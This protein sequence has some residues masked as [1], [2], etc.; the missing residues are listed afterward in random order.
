[1][2]QSQ[3]ISKTNKSAFKKIAVYFMVA[4]FA[5]V[6][7]MHFIKTETFALAMPNYLPEKILLVQL[8]GVIEIL[9]AVGLLISKTR[10]AAGICI[11]LFLVCVFPVNLNMALHP[12]NFH[13]VPAWALYLRLPIQGVLIWLAMVASKYKDSCQ[14][15]ESKV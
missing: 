9:G 7:I 15:L 8:T 12:E 6:G 13:A 4:L 1:M 5:G 3:K 2:S 10:R 14:K 11:A